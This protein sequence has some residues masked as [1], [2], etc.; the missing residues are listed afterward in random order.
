[1]FHLKLTYQTH[2]YRE[3]HAFD[4]LLG[5]P[6]GGPR[7]SAAGEFALAAFTGGSPGRMFPLVGGP[8]ARRGQRARAPSYGPPRWRVDSGYP[9]R[10]GAATREPSS[11]EIDSTNFRAVGPAGEIGAS[12][13][14]PRDRPLPDRGCRPRSGRLAQVGSRADLSLPRKPR[15]ASEGTPVELRPRAHTGLQH[16]P[17]MYTSGWFCLL[18]T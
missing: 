14:T 6:P 18:N 2:T 1:M 3:G 16:A 9:G 12:H 11:R 15:G 10:A 5:R 4:R 7:A 13:Q 8:G 17:L